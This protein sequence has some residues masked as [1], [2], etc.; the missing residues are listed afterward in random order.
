M[1]LSHQSIQRLSFKKAKLQRW[2]YTKEKYTCLHGEV[3]RNDFIRQRIQ[4]RNQIT[5]DFGNKRWKKSFFSRRVSRKQVASH[6]EISKV[7]VLKQTW[8]AINPTLSLK[9]HDAVK[10]ISRQVKGDAYKQHSPISLLQQRWWT[11]PS[12]LDLRHFALRR[13]YDIP[14]WLKSYVW[15]HGKHLSCVKC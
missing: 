12:C 10:S 4:N 3:I 1:H 14:L 5:A 6:D 11:L 8:Q 13:F 15:A 7:T 2:S 9:L